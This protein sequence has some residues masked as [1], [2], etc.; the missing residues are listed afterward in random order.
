MNVIGAF[1]TLLLTS[2]ALT[3]LV[4]QRVYGINMPGAEDL[5]PCVVINRTSGSTDSETDIVTARI[6][7]R[8]FASD[9]PGTDAVYNAILAFH[10]E[11]GLNAGAFHFY[12]IE[13]I[14]AAQDLR[15]TMTAAEF[16]NE[17]FSI[18]E[19]TVGT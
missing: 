6:D 7:V 15:E 19:I 18:W 4:G 8:C 5:F 11:D 3:D 16:W 13:E 2:T 10:G 9:Q 1:R 17:L 14:V 12:A